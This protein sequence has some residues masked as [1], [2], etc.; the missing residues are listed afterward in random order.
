MS[1]YP[2]VLRHQD[3]TQLLEDSRTQPQISDQIS[4]SCFSATLN[5][6]RIETSEMEKTIMV[7]FFI[8]SVKYMYIYGLKAWL[9]SIF[10]KFFPEDNSIFR[11]NQSNENGYWTRYSI[12]AES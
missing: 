2:V 1:V 4:I 3:L 5:N 10:T 7:S 8:I 6:S 9:I 12:F 11:M